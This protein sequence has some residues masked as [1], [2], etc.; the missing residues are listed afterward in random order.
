[1]IPYFR[2][3]NKLVTQR[4]IEAVVAVA[5]IETGILPDAGGWTDQAHTF[6]SAYPLIAQEIERWREKAAEKQRRKAQEQQRRKG[7]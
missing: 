2:C 7:R 5:R 1:M 4:E 6:V 3:P